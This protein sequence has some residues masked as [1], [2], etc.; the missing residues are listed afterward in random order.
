MVTINNHH[1]SKKTRDSKAKA[2]HEAT[3]AK[4]TQQVNLMISEYCDLTTFQQNL[5]ESC[6]LQQKHQQHPQQTFNCKQS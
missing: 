3:I 2:C 1:P 4:M 5:R 6:R